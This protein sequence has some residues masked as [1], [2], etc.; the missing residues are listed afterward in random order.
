MDH[1]TNEVPQKENFVLGSLATYARNASSYRAFKET[2][3]KHQ[4]LGY[5]VEELKL[6]GFNGLREFYKAARKTKEGYP[7]KE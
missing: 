6:R 1:M 7:T 5:S 2:L 3:V 4:A